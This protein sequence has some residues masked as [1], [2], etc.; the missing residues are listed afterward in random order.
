MRHTVVLWA[1]VAIALL[2]AGGVALAATKKGTPGN[3]RLVGT[4]KRDLL[5]GKGGQ[6][7]LYGKGSNDTLRGG[8]GRDTLRDAR[9]PSEK[10]AFRCGRGRDTVYANPNDSVADGC[11]VKNITGGGTGGG[12]QDL[13]PDLGMKP[14]RDVQIQNTQDGQRLLRFATVIVNVGAGSFELHGQR[15]DTTITD[16]TTTQRIFNDDGGHRDRPTAATLFYSG[17]GHDHWHVRNL[18]DYELF[19]KSDGQLVGTS[20]KN[21]F[22]FFGNERHGATGDSS[23]TGCA[24][25]QPQALQ[26]T[27]GLSRGW[28]DLYGPFIYGQFIDITDLPDGEYRLKVTA[29][30]A[31][32]F[33][34]EDETNNFTWADLQIS[35][36][37]V[38]VLEYGPS[39]PPIS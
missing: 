27:M 37:T 7:K 5:V 10:D 30:G 12:P 19:R 33:L 14:V 16:M 15:P 28:G 22:C 25:N 4:D 26:V 18:E 24:R 9:D 3:D 39:V 32:W 6:D 1:L 36:N 2:M 23:Y 21:G 8:K 38:T 35:G 29:D 11:E 34:E 20:P 13:L 17:D 31:D